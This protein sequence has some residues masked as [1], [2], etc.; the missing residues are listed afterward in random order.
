[1]RLL[2]PLLPVIM[3]VASRVV[4]ANW[5]VRLPRLTEVMTAWSTYQVSLPRL[6]GLH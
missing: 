2:V 1:M 3:H 4:E 5:I 6:L